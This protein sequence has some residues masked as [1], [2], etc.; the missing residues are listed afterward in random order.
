MKM[1]DITDRN[2]ASTFGIPVEQLD[3]LRK[4]AYLKWIQD[5]PVFAEKVRKLLEEAESMGIAAAILFGVD[6]S[7]DGM[8]GYAPGS[9]RV[10]VSRDTNPQCSALR[11]VMVSTVGKDT[12]DTLQRI[13][14]STIDVPDEMV[15]F[16]DLLAADEGTSTPAPTSVPGNGTV[17]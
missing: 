5:L 2:V 10:A 16:L 7:T 11:N 15:K 4:A 17:N 6:P 9:I 3:D 1:K 14:S 12:N 13:L 8:N